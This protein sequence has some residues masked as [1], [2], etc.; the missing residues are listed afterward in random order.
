MVILSIGAFQLG[1]LDTVQ[2]T[3][4][5]SLSVANSQTARD[6]RPS[7]ITSKLNLFPAWLGDC[8]IHRAHINTN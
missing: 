3:V 6:V 7:A 1:C 4:S 5:V 8:K 2:Y